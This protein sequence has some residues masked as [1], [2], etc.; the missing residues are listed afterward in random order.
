L[1]VDAAEEP[2]EEIGS[3]GLVVVGS[4]VALAL[5]GGPELD[6]GL[7]EGAGLAD[8]FEGA[9]QFGWSGAVAVAEQAVVVASES[10]H[11]WADQVGWE[12]VVLSV[13]GFDLLGDGEVFVSNGSVGDFGVAQGH[14]QAA[15]AEP[16]GDGF[17]GHAAVDGLG[18]QRMPEL[19]WV[20]VRQAGRGAGLV[21]QSGDGVPVQRAAVLP[22]VFPIL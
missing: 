5:Q 8:G 10:G 22:G 15:V 7:E 1:L 3:V 4:V 2:V 19:V 21:D 17:Q 11:P 9:V 18:G 12:R 20:D 14:V 6:A 13:Q 16:G